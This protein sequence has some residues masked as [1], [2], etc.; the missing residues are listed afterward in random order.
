MCCFAT[1]VHRNRQKPAMLVYLSDR[2]SR[3]LLV[4]ARVAGKRD[5]WGFDVTARTVRGFIAKGEPKWEQI[6]F[7]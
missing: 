1:S 7:G 4:Y 6:T 5:H 2:L 3:I